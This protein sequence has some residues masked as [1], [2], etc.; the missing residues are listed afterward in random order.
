MIKRY[1]LASDFDQTLSF[2]DS[3]VVLA[4]YMAEFG[5][6]QDQIAELGALLDEVHVGEAGD[7]VME[8]AKADEVAE[9]HA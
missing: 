8:A 5:V 4:A 6:V 1:L 3:G 9:D 7:L 2:N